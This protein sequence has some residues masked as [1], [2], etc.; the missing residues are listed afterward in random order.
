M[1]CVRL[2]AASLAIREYGAVDTL[3]NTAAYRL[4]DNLVNVLLRSITIRTQHAVEVEQRADVLELIWL[5]LFDAAAGCRV[6]S[7]TYTSAH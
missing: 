7:R 5:G 3:Q 1:D 2:A 4:S 6:S